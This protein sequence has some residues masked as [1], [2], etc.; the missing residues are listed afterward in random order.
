MCDQRLWQAC[1]TYLPENVELI[2][3]AIPV[4]NSIDKIVTALEQ[5]LPVGKINLAGFSLGGYIAS[6]F[7]LKYPNKINKLLLISNMSYLLPPAQLKERIRT[8]AYVKLHGY[9]GITSKRI[10]A[11]LHPSKHNNQDIINCIRAMD[12]ELGKDTLIHQLTVTT[13]RENLLVKLPTLAIPIQFLIGDNDSL[14]TLTR[15][16]T[17]LTQSPLISLITLAD[18]GHMLPLEQPEKCAGNMIRFFIE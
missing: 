10:T 17:I 1:I 7:A 6:A 5:K 15:I 2:H 18:T 4:E 13:Q 9:S 16:T 8:I 12:I 14:V 3:I 11:L